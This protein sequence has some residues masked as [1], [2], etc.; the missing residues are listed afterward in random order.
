[1][2]PVQAM[3]VP[4]I[5]SFGQSRNKEMGN[6]SLARKKI[7]KYKKGIKYRKKDNVRIT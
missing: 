3:V 1:V 2:I 6:G 5:Y 4:Y 7:A